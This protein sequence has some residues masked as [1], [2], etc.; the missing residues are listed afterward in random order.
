MLVYLRLNSREKEEY[1]IGTIEPYKTEF[2][3]R[4]GPVDSV[5]NKAYKNGLSKR[6]LSA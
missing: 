2:P 4:I 1:G 6:E 3:E 5:V